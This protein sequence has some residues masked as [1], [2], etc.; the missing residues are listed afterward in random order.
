MPKTKDNQPIFA[1]AIFSEPYDRL[2]EYQR[3]FVDF[4]CGEF[5]E[6]QREVGRLLRQAMNKKKLSHNDYNLILQMY[7]DRV[8]PL[9]IHLA[10]QSGLAAAAKAKTIPYAAGWFVVHIKIQQQKAHPT[11]NQGFPWFFENFKTAQEMDN[12]I[13]N[14]WY[15]N[16]FIPGLL[17]ET[18][19]EKRFAIQKQIR[20]IENAINHSAEFKRKHGRLPEGAR[21]KLKYFRRRKK[22][23]LKRLQELENG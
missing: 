20:G 19:H 2:D 7:L 23:L 4:H 21:N 1:Q 22:Q 17:I 6:Y 10:I 9:N 11:F 3:L 8:T 16:Q 18:P 5:R 12:V 14:P 15:G 13:F